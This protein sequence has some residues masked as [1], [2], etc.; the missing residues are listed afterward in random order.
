MGKRRSFDKEEARIDRLRQENKRL[1]HQISSLRKQLSRIDI[2]RYQN[3][4]DLVESQ[5]RKDAESEKSL[6]NQ[7]ILEQ[8]KCHS[9]HC[10]G[11]HLF[12]IPVSRRDGVFY[13]RKC[14]KCPNRT[15]LQKYGPDVKGVKKEDS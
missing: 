8:W 10:D 5:A 2:D 13:Y 7:K 14:D 1:K 4:K 12:I 9:P 6:Q 15:K 11:G 3:L